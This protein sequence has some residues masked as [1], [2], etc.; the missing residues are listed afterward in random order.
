MM[1]G[2]FEMLHQENLNHL[3]IHYDWRTDKFIFYAARDWDPDTDFS[4]YNKLFTVF[5]LRPSSGKYFNSAETES[6]FAKHNLVS[7]IEKIKALMRKGRH[8]FLD[9][10]YSEKLGIRF[11]NN[12]H[13]DKRGLNN[14]HSSLCM[15]G[16]RRHEPDEEELD[17]FID[18]MN[19]GRAMTF[20]NAAADLPMGG[21]KVTVQMKPID[22]DNL[23]QVGFLAY[24]NDRT[25]N[26][27]GPDMR[28]PPDLADVVKAHFSLHFTG[29]RK[30][31]LGPT[32]TPTAHGVHIAVKQAARFLWGSESLEGKKIV[33]QGLGA[34]GF[35]LAEDYIH[36][37][38][39]LV[40]CDVDPAKIAELKEKYPKASIEVVEPSN[41]LKV[42]A[43]IFSPCAMG[44]VLNE[45]NIPGLKF[46]IVMGSANNALKASSQEEEYT[47]ADLLAKHGIL[48]QVEWVHNIAGVM[49]GYEE[50]VYQEKASMAQLMEKAGKLCKEKTWENLNEAKR[51]GITPTKRAYLVV[52]REIYGE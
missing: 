43:D 19:L 42:E 13:S 34:V 4:Q 27:A 33:V 51:E 40:I 2:V 17:V 48:Y 16:I 14:L 8:I 50:Y 38:A 3:E 20:K 5:S 12:I 35:P 25:R 6:L 23:E 46:K 1:K 18:G 52:E 28:F 32:G 24:C 26:I 37:G 49:A 36:D 15:G 44:G 47:L 21:C 45:D 29:G 31:P 22:L 39:K 30:G 7:Y 9:C 41:V 11:V 10:Y